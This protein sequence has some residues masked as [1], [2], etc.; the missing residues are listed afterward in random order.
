MLH[1]QGKNVLAISTDGNSL[2]LYETDHFKII[3]TLDDDL[4][5]KIIKLNVGPSRR[6]LVVEEKNNLTV[7]DGYSG[8]K[9]F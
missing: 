5:L 6:I 4:D 9:A 7:Y 3:K 2:D 8:I 1:Y